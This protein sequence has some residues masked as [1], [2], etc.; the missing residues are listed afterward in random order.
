DPR[1]YKRRPR[2]DFENPEFFKY[3]KEFRQNKEIEY[4]KTIEIEHD[5]FLMPKE[6]SLAHCVAEDMN[7]GSGIAVQ[8]RRDFKK[9]DQLLNQRQKTGGLAV[10]QD[11]DRYIYYLVTKRY[12]SGKPTYATLFASLQKLKQ[13]IIEN[14]VAKLAMPRIGCG[15]DRLEWE[16]VKYMIEFVFRDVDVEIRICNLQPIEGSPQ[17][18]HKNCRVTNVDYPIQRIE[19]G[20]IIVYLSSEDGE[21][22]EE[23]NLLN[24]KFNFLNEFRYSRK[25]KG[26][27]VYFNRN[28]NYLLCG[29]IVKRIETDPIDFESFQTCIYDIQKTNKKYS[30]YYIGFQAI[31]DEDT[32]VNYKIMNILRNAMRDVE[33]YICWPG[34]L[35]HMIVKDRFSDYNP[36]TSAEKYT[37]DRKDTTDNWRNNSSS[38]QNRNR[39]ETEQ[40]TRLYQ[41]KIGMMTVKSNINNYLGELLQQ[42]QKE[43]G[44]AVLEDGSDYLYCLVIKQS[45]SSAPTSSMVFSSIQKMRDH[46]MSS[47]VKKIV[48]PQMVKCSKDTFNWSE[49]KCMLEYLFQK[50]NIDIFVAPFQQVKQKNKL[51]HVKSALHQMKPSSI[52]IYLASEDGYVSEEILSLDK[53]FKLVAIFKNSK[54]YLGD[55]IQYKPDENYV[56]YGCVVKKVQTDSVDFVALQ[57]CI[58]KINESNNKA[59][60]F[61]N[62]GIQAVNDNDEAINLK[63]ITV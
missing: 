36:K 22:S 4:V 39:V 25:S 35:Q 60:K 11:Y 15:L 41:Q 44:L 31:R 9:V 58:L 30:F 47:R 43:G 13:H 37:P 16:N 26:R 8:F 51:T 55:V 18:R 10:L 63:I 28:E 14:R 17:I 54:K 12:S 29:C 34:D 45:P 33:V 48:I 23:M 20:T 56:L 27:V 57:Q 32:I 2:D 40:E 38:T 61:S 50:R 3:E 53:R 7:M 5:L 59:E 46:A 62:V 6:Y 24:E 1:G 21:I 52:I 19:E 42:K 49:V